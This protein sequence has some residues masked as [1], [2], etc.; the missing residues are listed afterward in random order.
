MKFIFLIPLLFLLSCSSHKT[1]ESY[2]WLEEVE[3]KKALDWARAENEITFN[4]LKK[5]PRYENL[6]KTVYQTLTDKKKIPYGTIQGKYVYNFWR[7]KKVKRGQIR[8]QPLVSYIKNHKKWEIVLD[9]DKL[10]EKENE[11]WVYKGRNCLKPKYR[12]CL[13]R[14][15]RGGKDAAVY[16]EYDMKT[17]QF[18]KN[19]FKTKEGKTYVEWLD[20]NHLLIGADFGNNTLTKSGYPRIVKLWKRGL[21]LNKA[22]VVYEGKTSDTAVWS[23]YYNKSPKYIF[24]G[25]SIERYKRAIYLLDRKTLKVIT[26]LPLPTDVSW[27]GTLVNQFFVKLRSDLNIASKDYKKGSVLAFDIKDMIKNNKITKA[28]LLFEPNKMQALRRLHFVKD[29]LIISY[30]ENVKTRH[31]EVFYKSGKWVSRILDLPIKS[32]RVGVFST[33]ED[34]K[35]FFFYNESFLLPETLFYFNGNKSIKIRSQVS[36]FKKNNLETKQYFATSKDGTKVPYFIVSKNLKNKQKQT[37]T[38]IYAYGGF[39]SAM[40]PRYS[41]VLGKVWLEKGGQYVLANIRGGGEFGPSWHQAALRENRNRAF[42]DFYA[43]AQDVIDRGLSVSAKIGIKGGSNG[44]LLTAVALTQRPELY[45]AV[46]SAVP[47]ADM[48]RFHKLLAGH[49]WVGE[50]GNPDKKEDKDFL[51]KYSPFHNIDDNKTYPRAFI[52]TS[53][54]DDRVH[55]GHARKMVAKLKDY[56]QNVLYYENTEGGHAGAANYKQ[57]A[58]KI[59]LEYIYLYQELG[60]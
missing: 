29:K 11:N 45:K 35:D 28:K 52:T 50:Y 12:Y 22:K 2:L 55:P 56:N 46:I 15:S 42:E 5:D 20:R 10:A 57:T 53:T 17:K 43:V 33:D 19:G 26:K 7:G 32:G 47:L 34:R 39:E 3:G 23:Q 13:V 31:K 54:M 60:L 59:A 18:V 16:R 48:E 30:L 36:K 58:Q 8:R 4:K 14:L 41:P 24:I 1:N 49:S 38:L 9:I 51:L 44:G 27:Q 37:P 40:L 25:R 21:G 6:E